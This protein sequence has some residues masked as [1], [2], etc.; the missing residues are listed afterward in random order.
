[1]SQPA[2]TAATRRRSPGAGRA[3]RA[4][5]GANLLGLVVLVIMAFPVYWMVISALKPGRELFARTPQ[6]IP[7]DPTLANFSRAMNRDY[8]WNSVLNS[9]MVGFGAVVV[10]MIVGFLAAVAIARFRFY[11]RKAFLVMII[12]AQMLPLT[13]L[14]IPL[15]LL[16]GRAGLQNSLTGITITYLA[17]TLP[18]A[19]WLLRG[20]VSGIPA[21]LEEAAMVDGC[22]RV[23]AF[24]R[25]ILP[26][27]AP[28]L[29]ATSVFTFIQVWNEFLLANVL[30]TE[31]QRR[32][33]SI[34]LYGFI[35]N[36]GIDYAGLMAGSV[37]IALPVVVFFL[38]LN[39]RIAS[40]LVAGAVKG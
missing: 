12:S 31:P 2:A 17:L 4:R 26:L 29:V 30:L 18:L 3:R 21:E 37:L 6:F 15:F 11:G 14:V 35:T 24:F 8:F 28:G 27:V 7:T 39:R 32:T 20:F 25:I 5:I 1:M 22:T 10:S 40:G 19:I 9:V 36:Q 23:G 34:W 13:A 38:I 16:L 33:V